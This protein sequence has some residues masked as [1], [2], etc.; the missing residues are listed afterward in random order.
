VG[1]SDSPMVH[2]TVTV[3]CL[4]RLLVPALTSARTV[5]LSIVHCR[6]LQTTVGAVSRCSASTPDSPMLHR[7]V[8]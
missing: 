6:L 2:R 8:R 1:P 4:V 3:H 5:A 7:I